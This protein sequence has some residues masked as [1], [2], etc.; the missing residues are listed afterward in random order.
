VNITDSLKINWNLE[1]KTDILDNIELRS[2]NVQDILTTPPHWMVRWGNTVIFIILMMVLVMSWFIKYPEFIPAPIIV[3]SQNP[4][5]KIEARISSR[6]EKIL[7][8][9][10]QNVKKNDILMI[11]QST[12]NYDDVLKLK[13]LM[14][15]ITP[16]RLF[17]FPINQ[18]SNFRLG[19]IQSDYNS[20]AKAFQDEKLF[21]RLQPYSPD[22][23]AASEGLSEYSGRIATLKQQ[24]NLENT[25]FDL[26]KKNFSRSQ[27]LFDQ[28][29]ISKMELENEKIKYLQAEQNLKTIHISLSQLQEGI[30]NLQ[31]TKRSANINSEK[32]KINYSSQTLQLFE[33]LRKSL[34]QWEQNYLVVSSTNGVVSFQQFFGENQFVKSG[35]AIMTI[36][37]TDKMAVVGRM[38]VPSINSGKVIPGEKVLI[39]LDNYRY[40][41]YGI[42]E[43]KVQNISL[44]PDEKGNYYVDVILPR[45]L[46]TSYNKNLSFDKELKGN[47][48]IVTEDLRLIERFFYQIRRLLKFQL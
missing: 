10:H 1:T 7:I 34:K 12:A 32:D 9:D 31:K 42:V 8:K 47:A 25:K 39:K 2:E 20:F 43:G 41:E 18:T 19:E 26:S 24:L 35:D 30:S 45:G 16:G 5:E 29:V 40:Q 4:P 28:G 33:Q 17:S 6:I 36:L 15:S 46:K 23:L 38:Q 22:N 14:D 11:L 21:S 27:S 44:S 13:K 3:T 48:E 37:P